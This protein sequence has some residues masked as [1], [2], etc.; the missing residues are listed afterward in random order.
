MAPFVCLSLPA[1]AAAPLAGHEVPH[2]GPP[3]DVRRGGGGRP[4]EGGLRGGRAVLSAASPH[5]LAPPRPTPWGSSVTAK[6]FPSWKRKSEVEG[7][8][9]VEHE[10]MG[11]A[12]IPH[13]T[14]E[15]EAVSGFWALPGSRALHVSVEKRVDQFLAWLGFLSPGWVF[16][17]PC[18]GLSPR[19][20]PVC[21][22]PALP[23]CREVRLGRGWWWLQGCKAGSTGLTS[24]PPPLPQLPFSFAFF[25]GAV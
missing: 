14:A 17:P 9:R 8:D 6:P 25:L 5:G 23:A 13:G 22:P 12:G 20:A 4:R 24:I 21:C 11:A 1:A 7:S 16:C 3:R 2:P 18:V 10:R 15:P 19:F